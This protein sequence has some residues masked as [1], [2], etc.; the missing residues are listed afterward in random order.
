[1]GRPFQAE[2]NVKVRAKMIERLYMHVCVRGEGGGWKG[3]GFIYKP[4]GVQEHQVP[5]RRGR[6]WV[7]S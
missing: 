6:R 5:V 1:M 2:K 3:R 7:C 4:L